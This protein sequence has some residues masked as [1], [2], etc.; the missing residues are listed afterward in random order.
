MQKMPDVAQFVDRGTI[1]LSRRID[2]GVDRL[3]AAITKEEELDQWFMPTTIDLR[4]GGKFSFKGGWDGSIGRL[5]PRKN[6]QFDSEHGG[7]TRFEVEEDGQAGIFA[8]TDSLPSDFAVPVAVQERDGPLLSSQPGGP[9]THWVG[10]IAGWHAF[11]DQLERH[12]GGSTFEAT[13]LLGYNRLCSIY[14][15]LLAERFADSASI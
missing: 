6:I 5:E 3:W 10:V 8:L 4:V 7:F 1:T 15:I 2:V 13:H 12:L 14:E 11:V 9:G